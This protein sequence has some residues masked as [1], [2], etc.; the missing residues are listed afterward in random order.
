MIPDTSFP[1]ATIATQAEK[2][3]RYLFNDGAA[4]IA[5]LT[6]MKEAARVVVSSPQDIFAGDKQGAGA[7]IAVMEKIAQRHTDYFKDVHRHG[8]FF[9]RAA[10]KEG[11][12]SSLAKQAEIAVQD[13]N[14]TIEAGKILLTSSDIAGITDTKDKRQNLCDYIAALHTKLIVGAG[15]IYDNGLKR[16]VLGQRLLNIF[17]SAVTLSGKPGGLQDLEDELQIF[18]EFGRRDRQA[19][20]ETRRDLRA[21]QIT[22]R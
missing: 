20:L 21:Q 7:Y 22:L 18:T 15:K 8:E 17:D 11:R 3:S 1:A 12:T 14:A 9:D 6:D 4:R 16:D 5:A 13:L 2:V 19:V 10:G